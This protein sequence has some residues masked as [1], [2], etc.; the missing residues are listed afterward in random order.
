MP[1][2]VGHRPAC[3]GANVDELDQDAVLPEGALVGMMLGAELFHPTRLKEGVE[4]GDVAGRHQQVD[5]GM[6]PELPHAVQL[7]GPA[8]E[9]HR[10][11]AEGDQRV[12]RRRRV[13]PGR[14][15]RRSRSRCRAH[16]GDGSSSWSPNSRS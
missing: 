7:L 13:G 12:D 6:L 5:I 11:K 16:A 4:R 8:A 10:I 1:V 3:F 9:Q 14:R 15:P 2:K